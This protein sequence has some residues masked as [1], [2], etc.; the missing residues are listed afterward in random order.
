M[1]TEML[2]QSHLQMVST[3]EHGYSYALLEPGYYPPRTGSS[4]QRISPTGAEL[5]YLLS[6]ALASPLLAVDLE[7]RGS[8]PLLPDSEIIGI[9][10]AWNT[11]SFYVHIPDMGEEL[12]SVLDAIHKHPALL[13]HNVYFDGLWLKYLGGEHPHWRACTYGLYMQLA[14][15]GYLGQRWGLKQAEMDMLG[16]PESNEIELNNWLI[17]N[18][19]TKQGGSPRSSEMWRAPASILGPY[20]VLDAEACYLLYTNILEPQLRKFPSLVSYHE[21]DFL[22]LV[23]TLI[24]QKIH[25]LLVDMNKLDAAIE[26]LEQEVAKTKELFLSHEQV[27]GHIMLFNI[28]RLAE[29]DRTQPTKYKKERLRPEPA[30]YKKNGEVSKSWLIWKKWADSYTG[31]EISKNWLAWQEKRNKLA[32]SNQFNMRSG[33]HMRWLLY[34]QLRF[35][36]TEYTETGLPAVGEDALKQMGE[37]GRHL[38]AINGATKELEYLL[39]YRELARRYGGTIHPGFRVPGTLTGRLAGKEPNIQQMPKT[40]RTMQ[41]FVARPGTV[42]L[43]LDF[44]ALEPVVCTELSGDAALM[45]VYGPGV[46]KNDVYLY[47]GAHLPA[48]SERIRSTGYD[49][50]NPTP[51]ALARAKKECKHERNICKTLYL[52]AQ[53]GAGPGKIYKT[54]TRD[55]VSVSIEE[56][57]QLHTDYWNLYAGVKQFG[58]DLYREWKIS[59]GW[60][61]NGIGRPVCVDREYTKDL[62]NRVVQSTGHDLLMRYV[63]LFTRELDRRGIPWKPIIIDWHDAA[64]IEVPENYVEQAKLAMEWGVDELNRQLQGVIPLRGEVEIAHNLA[65]AKNPEK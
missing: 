37:L 59:G 25:G 38:I 42:W 15:E 2:L 1:S 31:P 22:Y 46:P 3:S 43:D 51:E 52:A 11:G 26:E 56:I 28:E 58:S 32:S 24:D 34:T 16:W 47:T 53:Y 12:Y 14:N 29:F 23:R 33:D 57:Q 36:P 19:Y 40:K 30:R 13:A 9:G 50:L 61:Y 20:C 6:L 7:T 48:F 10:L 21:E 63:R 18:G 64:T 65:E 35:E 8:D 44:A 41:C 62:V 39:E 5:E 49:P 17:E 45:G 55:G 4:Y 27:C 54:L 60:V